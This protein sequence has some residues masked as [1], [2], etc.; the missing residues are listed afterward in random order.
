[1][2]AQ[3]KRRHMSKRVGEFVVITDPNRFGEVRAEDVGQ[4]VE[5]KNVGA[6]TVSVTLVRMLAD[7]TWG[8]KAEVFGAV[9]VQLHDLGLLSPITA[10]QIEALRRFGS[11]SER[12]FATWATSQPL[13]PEGREVT[14]LRNPRRVVRMPSI[15]GAK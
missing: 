13:Q 4:I 9:D 14:F 7:G 6:T 1:M 12:E 2:T 3:L 5:V 11:M 15:R 8:E 10:V